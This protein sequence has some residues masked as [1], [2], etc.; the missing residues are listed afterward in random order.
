MAQR[1]LKRVCQNKRGVKAERGEEDLPDGAGR[2]PHLAAQVLESKR[3][4]ESERS[5]VASVC[6]SSTMA[7][8]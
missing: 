1:A 3:E 6:H 4:R 2:A 7:N 5:D 8:G